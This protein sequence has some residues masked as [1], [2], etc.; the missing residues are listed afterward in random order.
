MG[1]DESHAQHGA[2]V[3]VVTGLEAQATM[4]SS[5]RRPRDLAKLYT[6]LSTRQEQR[7]NLKTRDQVT[8]Y[9]LVTGR[10]VF[11]VGSTAVTPRA[12]LKQH[13][14]GNLPVSDRIRAIQ[15]AGGKVTVKVLQ[16]NAPRR[17]SHRFANDG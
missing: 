15:E 9:A 14:Q 1:V 13:K 2:A 4:S 17:K 12:R 11:Y 5:P 3:A 8:I 10:K 6:F 7:E 16:E